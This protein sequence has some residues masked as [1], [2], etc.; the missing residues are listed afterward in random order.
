MSRSI[1]HCPLCHRELYNLHRPQCL[2]CGARLTEAEFEQV[3]LP[4]GAPQAPLPQPMPMMPPMTGM[5]WSG[6]VW[7]LFEGNPFA[8]IKQSVS[9][10]ERELRIVGAALFA[11]L[12]LARL[13]YFVWDLWR[14][15]HPMPPMR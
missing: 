14:M 6:R 11:C 8:L 7:G 10:W 9:P 3:A 5:P 4:P 12:M 15:Q 2:W 1:I 13:V